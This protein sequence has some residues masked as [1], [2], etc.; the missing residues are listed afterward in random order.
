[1]KGLIRFF[2]SQD[3]ERK[4]E[5]VHR[6]LCDFLSDKSVFALKERSYDRE[7]P[8]ALCQSVHLPRREEKNE[9]P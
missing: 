8:V 6:I 9:R 5:V 2:L 1:M 3:E 7:R 4:T